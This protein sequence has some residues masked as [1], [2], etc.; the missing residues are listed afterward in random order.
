MD[1]KNKI[2][3]VVGSVALLAVSVV[4]G[5]ALFSDKANTT[6]A[7]V[8]TSSASTNTSSSSSVA[9]VSTTPASEE[10]STAAAK[11]T[12]SYKDGTYTATVRYN[13]P[14]GAQNQIA[15]TLTV[16]GSKITA[17][18]T[19]DNYTDRESGMYVNSFESSVSSDA[20]GQ[21]IA[22][23]SPSRVGGASLTT[24]AFSDA[25]DQIRTAASA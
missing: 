11:T 20:T 12:T 25:I 19:S 4:G 24:M 14:H 10:N 7:S 13:V 17:V 23:Y 1:T 16:A 22:S 8:A 3:T 2:F 9:A 21:P 5:Y 18:K 15:V 6:T